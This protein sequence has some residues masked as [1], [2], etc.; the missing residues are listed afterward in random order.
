MRQNA[1]LE[2]MENQ[3]GTLS[4]K[5]MARLKKTAEIE[6]ID[7]AAARRLQKGYRYMI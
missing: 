7:I 4:D 5:D 2:R 6:G 3:D 1:Q